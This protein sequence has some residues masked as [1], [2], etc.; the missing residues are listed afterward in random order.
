MERPWTIIYQSDTFIFRA[1]TIQAA[2]YTRELQ[3]LIAGEKWHQFTLSE[4]ET[5]TLLE[6][7]ITTWED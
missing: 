7:L 1:R 2:S 6:R 4:A 5:K 3:V